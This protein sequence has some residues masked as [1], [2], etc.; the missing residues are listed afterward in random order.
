MSPL[1][2][3]LSRLRRAHGLLLLR[4]F[5]PF[6][7]RMGCPPGPQCLLKL[8]RQ[9]FGSAGTGETAT[10]NHEA[11]ERE[12]KDLAAKWEKHRKI[13]KMQGLQWHCFNCKRN[14]PKASFGAKAHTCQEVHTRCV[15]PGYWRRCN[16]CAAITYDVSLTDEDDQ[17]AQE[18]LRCHQQRPRGYFPE[19]GCVCNSCAESWEARV[20]VCRDCGKVFKCAAG[21]VYI[22]DGSP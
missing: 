16:A 11:A 17:N 19:Q 1:D 20:S 22:D 5:S 4:A 18:C 13:L 3:I 21:K 2:S 14:L 10:Y 15:A 6:L 12:Y 8:L 7:F 9:R